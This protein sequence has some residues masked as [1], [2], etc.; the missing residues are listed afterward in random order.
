MSRA[1]DLSRLAALAALQREAGLSRLAAAAAAC[2]RTE[3]RIA[4]LTD[5]PPAASVDPVSAE[6]NALAYARWASGQR[7]RL[8]DLLEGEARARDAARAAA[9]A[10]FARASVVDRLS[11]RARDEARRDAARRG[12]PG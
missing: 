10:A 4:A 9:A 6:L 5:R 11:E 8:S 12:G 1:S 7:R 2:A 3:A